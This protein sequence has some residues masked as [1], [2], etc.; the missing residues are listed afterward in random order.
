MTK[1]RVQAKPIRRIGDV[2]ITRVEEMCGPS[3]S[4]S[5][6]YADWTPQILE[7]NRH[8]LVPDSFH[9]AKGLFIGSVHTWIVRTAYHTILIDTCCGNDKQRPGMPGF[10]MLKFPFLERLRAAGVAPEEVDYVLC[11]HL[12]VDH[13]GWNTR[14]DNGRWVPTFPNAKYI[15]SK[16]ECDHWADPANQKDPVNAGVFK[17]SV[18]PILEGGL[19]ELVDGA[20]MIGD[21]L[22][23]D[24]SPG[25]SP[26][27]VAILLRSRGDQAI[28]SGDLMHQPVQIVYPDWNSCFCADAEMARSSRKRILELC[29]EHRAMLFPAHFGGSHAGFVTKDSKG[30]HWTYD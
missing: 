12:H 18:L 2:T 25:H 22:T 1:A 11:T 13:C 16:A 20:G 9:E 24:P 10:H 23:I 15:F 21:E 19:A 3:F 8:W 7:E 5:F 4:P 17:D 26:G 29:V 27:H 30:F 6:L 14:L 28:F